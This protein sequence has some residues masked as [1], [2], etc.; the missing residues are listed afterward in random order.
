[1]G[2]GLGTYGVVYRRLTE[3]GSPPGDWILSLTEFAFGIID[4]YDAEL[5]RGAGF[6]TSKAVASVRFT[7]TQVSIDGILEARILIRRALALWKDIP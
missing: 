5:V 3:V 7:S 4:D 1:M 2:A 6:V